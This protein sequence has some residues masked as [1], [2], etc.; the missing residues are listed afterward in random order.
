MQIERYPRTHLNLKPELLRLAAGSATLSLYNL[1]QLVLYAV[2]GHKVIQCCFDGFFGRLTAGFEVGLVVLD[3]VAVGIEHLAPIH[4][5]HLLNILMLPNQLLK[6]TLTFLSAE[7][8]VPQEVL[9]SQLLVLFLWSGKFVF[10][11]LFVWAV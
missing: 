2:I 6:L 3:V 8:L 5:I 1:V 9:G 7:Q 10:L 4:R 11:V